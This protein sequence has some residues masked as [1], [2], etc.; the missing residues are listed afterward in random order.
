MASAL[1]TEEILASILTA[2]AINV[3]PVLRDLLV[4][5]LITE[6]IPANLLTAM[7]IN[8]QQ[9]LGDLLTFAL[10]TAEDPG[11]RALTAT[12]ISVVK[13][14]RDLLTFALRTT[15]ES[16]VQ[17]VS[18]GLTVDVAKRNLITTVRLVTIDCFQ[19]L[20]DRGFAT[21]RPKN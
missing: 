1:T 4:S 16:G 7:A 19:T 20:N 3:Q 2:M 12:A 6:V 10:P 18:T 5:A 9:A 14:L 15:E 13:A 11:V 21:T 8:V 17:I